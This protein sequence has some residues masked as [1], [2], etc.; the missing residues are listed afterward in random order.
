MKFGLMYE[1]AYAAVRA[2][3][4]FFFG[5]SDDEKIAQD[6]LSP[7]RLVERGLLCAG[8]PDSCIKVLER[9]EALGIDLVL[10]YMEMGR[11]PHTK[12][13]ES[14]KMMG[15]YV[16]PYFKGRTSWYGQQQPGMAAR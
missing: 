3:E 11:V 12:T 15:K 14:I 2:P 7:Q 5:T 1:V 6:E 16:I 9:F 4:A 13:M 10:C 8:N